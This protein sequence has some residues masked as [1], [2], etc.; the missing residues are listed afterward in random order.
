MS[1]PLLVD[2]EPDCVKPL[3]ITRK[4]FNVQVGNAENRNWCRKIHTP[5]WPISD[6]MMPPGE[7][8]SV[9]QAAAGRMTTL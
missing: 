2:D 5:D 7:W 6:V 9:S 8:L 4:C 3:K 1:A